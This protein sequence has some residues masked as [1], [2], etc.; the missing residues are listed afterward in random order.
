MD[1]IN[2]HI[3]IIITFL[4]LVEITIAQ[5]IHYSQFYLNKLN[6]NPANAG[7]NDANL[8]VVANY[9]DQWRAVP[10]AYK[11]MSLTADKKVYTKGKKSSIGTGIVLN[12]D[13]AGDVGLGV[14]NAGL[15]V[16]ADVKLNAKMKLGGGLL[17]N[18]RQ[19]SINKQSMIWQD[20]ITDTGYDANLNTGELSDF[21]NYGMMDVSMGVN[22]STKLAENR[23][24]ANNP[25]IFNAGIAIYHLNSPKHA[26]YDNIKNS[27]SRKMIMNVDARIPIEGTNFSIDPSGFLSI[28]S[29]YKDYMIGTLVR[30]KLKEGSKYTSY[31]KEAAIS[32]GAHYRVKSDLVISSMLEVSNFNFGL[33]Y[34]INISPSKI[35]SRYR[36]GTEI[37][38]IYYIPK[39][40]TYGKSRV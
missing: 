5:D 23:M 30:Y 3:K 15:A 35:V 38:I 14:M 20:Q 1:S 16:A 37:S 29:V 24:S 26:Y 18:Y 27:L 25:I 7:N 12:R 19:Y 28:Q 6:I 21:S 4:F 39:P 32:L 9:K 40:P 33:S 11:T 31:E 10:N 8:R 36:G 13:K 34:D 22:F 17:F 2:K